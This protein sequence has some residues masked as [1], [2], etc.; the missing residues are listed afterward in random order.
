MLPE[1]LGHGAV[2]P[3]LALP[4]GQLAARAVPQ[5][6]QPALL[7]EDLLLARVSAAAHLRTEEAQRSLSGSARRCASA[8]AAA[9]AQ[10]NKAVTGQ[11][12]TVVSGTHCG[13]RLWQLPAHA[14]LL[15][16]C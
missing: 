12:Q 10:H 13:A 3:I 8:G 15:A 1:L 16:A 4:L 14:L 5:E 6:E 9:L 11:V 2:A 7:L